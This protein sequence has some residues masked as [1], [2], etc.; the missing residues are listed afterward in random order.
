MF[1][2][3][4]RFSANKSQAPNLMQA[5]ND[6][7][8]RGFDDGVFLLTGSL[9]PGLGGTV[10]AHGVTRAE[11]EARLKEDPFVT[12]DVVSVEILEIAPGRADDRLAFLL[13]AA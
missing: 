8:R 2:V 3:A 5:H 6:W 13:A 7:I 11:L 9:K 1:V 10:L 12:E 4:L